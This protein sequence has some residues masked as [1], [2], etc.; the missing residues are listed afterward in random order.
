MQCCENLLRFEARSMRQLA[1][2]GLVADLSL[3]AG[4]VYFRSHPPAAQNRA[5]PGKAGLSHRSVE[6]HYVLGSEKSP[7]FMTFS[8]KH[9]RGIDFKTTALH[10]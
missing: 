4:R 8:K 9:K 10:F 7:F 6:L 1:A 3:G 5:K 2:S